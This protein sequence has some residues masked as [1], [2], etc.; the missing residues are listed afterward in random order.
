MQST[1]SLKFPLKSV[2]EKNLYS[3]DPN[4][5]GQGEYLVIRAKNGFEDK[6]K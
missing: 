6:K 4:A 5:E 2:S 1:D 3:Q